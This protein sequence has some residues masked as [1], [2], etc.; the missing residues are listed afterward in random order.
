MVG[1][2]QERRAALISGEALR[3]SKGN[4]DP[5]MAPW[6]NPQPQTH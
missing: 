2:V 4:F 5:G 6:V 3:T 1:G